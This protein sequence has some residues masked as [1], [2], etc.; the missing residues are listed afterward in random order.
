MKNFAI[1][2]A[3]LVLSVLTNAARG[4]LAIDWSTTDG[5]G[6]TTSTAGTI[7]LSGT[8][9]QADAGSMGS[10]STVLYGGFWAGEL[11]PP[12]CP[13]DYNQDGG[14]D[15]QDV[16]PFFADWENGE[17][18]ADVNQDGGIDGQ[19]VQYFFEVWEAGGC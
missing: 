6:I 12:P 9:G 8:I 5:G 3:A 13:A 15:G 19:D 4:Q 7:E 10:G 18:V 1:L 14:V 2:V 16:D 11:A 17:M